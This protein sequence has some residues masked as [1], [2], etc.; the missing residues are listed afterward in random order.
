[1]T[2]AAH[3]LGTFVLGVAFILMGVG[4]LWV[5]YA[6]ERHNLFAEAIYDWYEKTQLV[7]FPVDTGPLIEGIVGIAVGLLFVTGLV[8]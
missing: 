4:L 5:R 8:G 3:S 1:M 7:K 2:E 6:H